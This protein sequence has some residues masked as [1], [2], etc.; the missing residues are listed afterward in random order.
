MSAPS[1]IAAQGGRLA[2]PAGPDLLR[3]V[4]DP[5]TGINIVDLGLIYDVSLSGDGAV[6]VRMTLTPPG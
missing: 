6:T 2:K 3:E 1:T 4:I 5:E